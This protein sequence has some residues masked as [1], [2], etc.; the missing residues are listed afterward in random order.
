M[1]KKVQKGV[2]TVVLSSM[3]LT[4]TAFAASSVI[5]KSE[6]VYVL[7][8]DNNVED[9][10]VSVWL[11]SEEGIKGKDKS[12]L[13]NVK[14]LKTDEKI[15]NKN[16]Y[17]YWDENIK[18]IYYQGKSEENIP[19]DVKI[20]YYLD[21][22]KMENSE[23]EGKSGHLKLVISTENNKYVIKKINGKK[24]KVYAP[25]TVI[26]AMAF[27]QEIASNIES[28]DAKIAKDGKNEVVTSILTPGLKENFE[29]ILE[30][31][32]MEE[33]KSEAVVEMDVKDYKPVEAYVVISNELFQNKADLE[34]IDKLRDGVRELEDNSQKLVDA[35]T[36]LSD[37][38]GKLNK[39]I[40]E[41]GDGTLKLKDGSKK[42]YEKSGEFQDK[43]D[44]VI[45]KVEPV[46]GAAQKM[47][48][49][50]SKL[51]SGISDYTSAVG[52][53]NDKTGEMK[54]GAKKL[55]DG[56][57]E[58]DNGLGKLKDATVQLRE[59]SS[60]LSKIDEMKEETLKKLAELKSGIEKLSAGANKLDAG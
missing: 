2:I 13:K 1:N 47:Y 52:K 30:D 9:K 27:P 36:K 6:T 55:H 58:L 46:P 12:N 8:K 25:Y 37:A 20:D 45:E 44:E 39:G 50:G 4:N 11:N 18:D 17:I 59:G 5:N 24:T 51:T 42:L 40:N 48:E 34:T 56:S 49:G 3:I 21:G 19:I 43:L 16:G 32:Q 35:S 14:N 57:V 22:E 28:D 7:K 31:R 23:L 10:T 60:K 29:T 53:M 26:A 33:F 41:L 54:D 15:E 38:Q